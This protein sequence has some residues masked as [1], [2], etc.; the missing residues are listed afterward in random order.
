MIQNQKLTMHLQPFVVTFTKFSMNNVETSSICLEF[1]TIRQ[2]IRARSAILNF[3]KVLHIFSRAYDFMINKLIRSLNM[4]KL[5]K[6][7][8]FDQNTDISFSLC[9]YYFQSKIHLSTFITL[10]MFSRK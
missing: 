3:S 1:G 8:K 9:R 4:V 2:I 6:D 7:L 5:S 10:K